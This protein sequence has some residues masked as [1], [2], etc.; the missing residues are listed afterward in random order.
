MRYLFAARASL[1]LLM[2]GTPAL[3]DE[4]QQTPQQTSP[5]P[6]SESLTGT[7]KTDYDSGKVL[8]EDGD[9][10][11]ALVKFQSAY[12]LSGD[13]RLL[14]N[15]A[16]CEKSLRHY[17]AVLD[18]LAEYRRLAQLTEEERGQVDSLMG[19]LG[20]LVSGMTV[21]GA[22]AGAE[23]YVDDRLRGVLPLDK[24]IL[25]DLG[26]RR[27]RV[28]RDGYEAHTETLQVRGANQITVQAALRPLQQATESTLSVQADA[29]ARIFV[30][31]RLVG[32]GTFHGNIEPGL[33]GI[34]VE[35]PGR[36]THHS[37][38][39][40]EPGRERS[41]DIRLAREAEER[42]R[43]VRPW[44]WVAGGA[45]LASGAAVGGYALFRRDDE[46]TP[47]GP[48]LVQG[49]LQPGSVRLP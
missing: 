15:V 38:V 28:Q 36:R 48:T 42:K 18:L 22:P 24:P 34:R 13:A 7:A 17:A 26:E 31:E 41:L 12:E 11:G 25:L 14:W 3:A 16:A 19:T 1:W 2:L 45:V 23:V 37:E 21:Q 10:A 43:G 27:V 5:P 39:T 8:Y 44:V 49:T 4:L 47:A 30:D 6:L 9:Y 40:L 32:T 20:P 33:H 29:D 35:A 46:S